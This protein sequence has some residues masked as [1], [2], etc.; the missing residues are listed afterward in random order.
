VNAVSPGLTRTDMPAAEDLARSASVIPM[1]RAGE[2]DEIAAAIAFL[3]SAD[4]AY[5]A[6]ANLRVSG[7]R[8]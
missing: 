6:G 7:G 1:G 8:P 3:L 2:P 4:A 5:V